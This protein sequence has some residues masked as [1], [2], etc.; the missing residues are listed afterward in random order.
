MNSVL[1][2][3]SAPGPASY[4]V[5]PA[6]AMHST[7]TA[8]TPADPADSKARLAPPPAGLHSTG[9]PLW[10]TVTFPLYSCWL[11]QAKIGLLTWFYYKFSCSEPLEKQFSNNNRSYDH[12][13]RRTQLS[14]VQIGIIA[15]DSQTIPEIQRTKCICV[16]I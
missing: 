6:A 11:S 2:L 16:G 13:G 4:R 15:T 3:P 12:N 9:S 5:S 1:W 10:S 8:Q 7:P 14:Y